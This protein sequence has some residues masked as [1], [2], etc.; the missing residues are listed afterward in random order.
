MVLLS[1]YTA[2]LC[3]LF[4]LHMKIFRWVYKSCLWIALSTALLLH[5][6]ET[7]FQGKPESF[8]I[9]S[10]ASIY[11]MGP[12]KELGTDATPILLKAVEQRDGPNAA[13]IRTNAAIMLSNQQDPKVLIRLAMR[14]FD[15]QVRMWATDG[16]SQNADKPVTA[17]LLKVLEDKDARVRRSAA[18]GLALTEREKDAVAVN[19]LVRHL[20]DEDP[21]VRE[22]VAATLV[23]SPNGLESALPELKKALN[24]KDADIRNSAT[25]ALKGTD[26][27]MILKTFELASKDMVTE[28]QGF[29]WALTLKVVDH[30]NQ[31]VEG[32]EVWVSWRDIREGEP[33]DPADPN[34]KWA[35]YGKTD[36]NGLFKASHTDYS[37]VLGLQARKLG[38][39]S[40]R[41]GYDLFMPAQYD[42]QRVES[43]RNA[44]VTLVLKKVLNPT[45]MYI[46]RVDIAHKKHPAADKAL[47]FDLING[48]WNA[49]Y[50]R[51][52][53]THLFFTWH[54]DK[55]TNGGW[56]NTLTVGFPNLG[57]G[58][59]EFDV[60][61]D[62]G[63][64][65]LR[66]PYEA[67]K[68]GYQSQLIKLQS[69]HKNRP[70]TNTYDHLHKNYFLR[71]QTLLDE[72]GKVKSAQYGK[73]YGD[74]ESLF[75]TLLNP[76]VNSRNIE[77]DPKR[78]F[79][80][81][82]RPNVNV[83]PP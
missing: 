80:R 5:A 72:N 22:F 1:V 19:A 40:Y 34:V 57:D 66:S 37:T 10:L 21:N 39:Y 42:N 45:P 36:S 68:D 13:A 24:S 53:N 78:N 35:F 81:D 74:F 25:A 29:K 27:E 61:S 7:L 70:G 2:K 55:D 33:I 32:A 83:G 75:W 15:P 77:S 3:P 51:G 26:P 76:E 69:W 67:P 49:P 16:L 64:S 43:N 41:R 20:Q 59:Q 28:R 54:T 60:P 79:P 44:T 48:D 52:T 12:I 65:D 38:Y 71:V 58:I 30:L 82:P 14:N 17:A 62:L 31:P 4:K 50:G 18:I 9:N 46:N 6:E 23:E 11:S 8:W 63:D 47:G 56:D 73:I